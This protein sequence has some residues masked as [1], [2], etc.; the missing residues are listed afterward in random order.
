MSECFIMLHKCLTRQQLYLFDKQ[1][2]QSLK[3]CTMEYMKCLQNKPPP[4]AAL[5]RILHQVTRLD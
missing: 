5:V 4:A 1:S 3:H 2:A